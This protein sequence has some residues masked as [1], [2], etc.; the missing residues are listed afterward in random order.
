MNEASSAR[1]PLGHVAGLVRR[2]RWPVAVAAGV[3]LY[4]MLGFWL[5]PWIVRGQAVAALEQRLDRPVSLERLRINPFV[6]SAE[7]GNFRIRERDG[8][9]LAGFDR[10]YVNF[11]LSSLFRWAWTFREI[12]LETPSVD[13]VRAENGAINV[14]NLIGGDGAA[15]LDEEPAPALPRLLIGELAV[16][17]GTVRIV[18]RVPETDFETVLGPVDVDVQDLNTLPEQEGQYQ[19]AVTTEYGSRLTWAGSLGLAPFY[20]SG[21][22]TGA[23]PFA[24]ILSRFLQ[25]DVA[26]ML[27]DGRF[28]LAFDY[29]V[30]LRADTEFFATVG[31]TDIAVLDLALERDDTAM[32]FLAVPEVRLS[33]G[34]LHWPEKTIDIDRLAVTGADLTVMRSADGA[35][36]LLGLVEPATSEQPANAPLPAGDPTRGW[37]ISL[38][39]LAIA[40]LSAGFADAAPRNPANL[41]L[42]ALDLNVHEI[43][44]AADARFPFELV[45]ELGSGGRIESEG[46][47]GMLPSVLADGSVAVTS[48]VL[49]AV[50]PYLS[51][52]A[53]VAIEGGALDADLTVAVAGD[54]TGSVEG[55][56]TVSDLELRDELL[57][58]RLV[59]WSALDVDG[60]SVD[61]EARS[62]A[63][64]EIALHS[65][66]A[67]LLIERD[68]STN[69]Q[70]LLVEDEAGDASDTESTAADELV[71]E[72]DDTV[73]PEL[74]IGRL[75]ID[76]GSSDFTDLSLPLPFATHVTGLTGALST[77]VSTSSQ[78]A[79]LELEGQVEE[80]GLA[81]VAGT[82]SP[83]G[84]AEA[85]DMRVLFRNVAMP[86]LSPYTA[87]FAGRTMAD[88]RLDLDL[89]YTIDGG[90]LTG[91]NDIVIADL[92][93]GERVDSPDAM[94]LPLDLAVAL[95]TGPDGRISIDLPVS[96]DL[97]D[98]QFGIGSVVM[99]ALGN[100]I[101]GLV[102]APFRLLGRLIGVDSEDF[103]EIEFEPGN[104]ELTPPERQKL[105]Q[106]SEAL[107]LRPALALVVAGAIAPDADAAALRV[108]RVAARLDAAAAA[109]ASDASL[110]E[111]R[112]QAI[113]ADFTQRLPGSPLEPIRAEFVRPS[114]PNDPASAPVFDETA[115]LAAL[116]S[117]L[118]ESEPI[119]PADLETLAAARAGAIRDAVTADGSIELARV[120]LGEAREVRLNDAGWIPLELDVSEAR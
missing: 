99:G 5:A 26:F 62:V 115:Y 54:G 60:L 74:S 47:I 101:T 19:L 80:Y 49:S 20:S 116:T 43:T 94:D 70:A 120:E 104:A 30:G 106:L 93:L 72:R 81:R 68:N 22:V 44:T 98:P 27:S 40:G 21:R 12:R 114:D 42:A 45:A 113:E 85:M 96:G 48:L 28:E 66:Y 76:D 4:A 64:S 9:M 31:N 91:Q 52:L 37:S 84:P 15:A 46:M 2:Y 36:N 38:G 90:T 109:I 51:E 13:L 34:A 50:Q 32:P 87:E 105:A 69:F 55:R 3:V 10:L 97:D 108:S 118:V 24:A 117:R 83:R 1:V 112:R 110:I 16:A 78:P 119:V 75:T 29:S 77:L 25:D 71:A 58:E 92:R 86:D 57:E 59:G 14:A 88:G 63:L 23:G 39:E 102:T 8:S 82:I 89:H 100:L 41:E 61:L 18:D 73:P 6:L 95:L 7:L 67:R 79:E 65:P 53:H 17:G 56:F 111:R 35:I 103:D 33:G 11:Q 107:T